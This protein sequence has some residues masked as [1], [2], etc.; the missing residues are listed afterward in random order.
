MCQ[1]LRIM[2]GNLLKAHEISKFYLSMLL[3]SNVFQWCMYSAIESQIQSSQEFGEGE[4]GPA[5]DY[6]PVI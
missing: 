4:V 1:C 2:G 6:Q 5:F 3:P